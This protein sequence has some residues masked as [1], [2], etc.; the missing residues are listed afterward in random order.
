MTEENKIVIQLHKP[1]N[2]ELF[3]FFISG[4]IVSVPLTLYAGVFSNHLCVSVPIL[5]SVICSTT[6]MVPFIEEFAKAFPLFYRHG[7]TEKSIFTLGFLVGLGFG[8]TEFFVYVIGSGES[9]Y[10]RLPAMLF[11]A[12]STSITAYGIAIKRPMPFYLV[13]AL[14]HL[15][16]NFLAT[17]SQ[18]WIPGG[19]IVLITTYFLSWHLYSKTREKMIF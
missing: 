16:N 17:N 12:A 18:Y 9:I 13:A 1:G 4:V 15:M 14:L 8:V 10:S 3:F 5:Y 2:K 7:E 11:H 6:I 19:P